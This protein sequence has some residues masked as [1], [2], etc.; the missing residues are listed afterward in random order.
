M[1]SAGG[2]LRQ[3]AGGGHPRERVQLQELHLALR[4]HDDVGA[5]GPPAAQGPVRREAHLVHPR[6]LVR[7]ERGGEE[8][9]VP[10]PALYLA[11]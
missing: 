5:G 4:G 9:L 8:I 6:V 2:D 11:S 1:P 7:R 3:Q 10:L